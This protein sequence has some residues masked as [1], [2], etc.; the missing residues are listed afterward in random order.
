M[1]FSHH[2]C[3]LLIEKHGIIGAAYA[4][5]SVIIFINICKLILILVKFKIHPYSVKTIYA[6][7]IALIQHT[8][9]Y[10]YCNY[11]RDEL[12]SNNF[13]KAS[14]VLPSVAYVNLRRQACI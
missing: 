5:L 9:A 11:N 4:T 7:V 2:I 1:H 3:L 12:R 10:F 14:L 13:P 6:F 8:K